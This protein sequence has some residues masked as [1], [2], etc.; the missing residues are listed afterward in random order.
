M[1]KV[2]MLAQQRTPQAVDH[3]LLMLTT[4]LFTFDFEAQG[5]KINLTSVKGTQGGTEPKKCGEAKIGRTGLQGLDTA[6]TFR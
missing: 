5:L 2:A 1:H 3:I 4:P 6:K